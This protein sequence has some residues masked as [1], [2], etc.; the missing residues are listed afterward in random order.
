MFGHGRVDGEATIVD[1]RTISTTGDGMVSRHEYVAD[2]RAPG[3]E[4]FRTVIGEP[5]ITTDF[6]PPRVGQTVKVR[7]DVEKQSA[8]FDKDDPALSAKAQKRARD[9]SFARTAAAPPGS[10][11]EPGSPL[12]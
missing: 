12:S 8:T 2:V 11:R 4:P 10:G 1:L 9:D 6:W 3:A 7:V 5:F